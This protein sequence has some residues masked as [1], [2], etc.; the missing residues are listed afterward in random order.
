MISKALS[1]LRANPFVYGVFVYIVFYVFLRIGGEVFSLVTGPMGLDKG[2]SSALSDVV[3]ELFAMAALCFILY[4]TG[5]IGLLTKR[6]KGFFA[7]L[8]VGGYCLLFTAYSAMRN[9]MGADESGDLPI[10]FTLTSFFYLFSFVLVGITEEIEARALVGQTFLEHYGLSREGIIKA[11][12]F[13]GIIFGLMHLSNLTSQSLEDTI[14]QVITAA[15]GGI[16]YGAIYFRTGNLWGVAFFHAIFDISLSLSTAFFDGGVSAAASSSPEGLSIMAILF[17]LF[18]AAADVA[19]ALY[20]LRDEKIGEV[21]EAWPELA[22]G[23]S[24]EAQA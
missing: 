20:L 24:E 16:L 4:K 22:A 11:A 2:L 23:K 6:G 19:V 1:K 10:N 17:S 9:F 18:T 7:A 12:V 21:A 5:K 15:S 13:S 8:G 14:P 3:G